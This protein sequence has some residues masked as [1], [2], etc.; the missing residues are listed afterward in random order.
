MTAPSAPR[1]TAVIAS[2]SS[3]ALASLVRYPA[4]PSASAAYTSPRLRLARRSAPRACA[5][6]RAPPRS[7]PARPDRPVSVLSITAT[8]GCCAPIAVERLPAVARLPDELELRALA[9]R[10]RSARPGR[11]AGRPRPGRALA[12]LASHEVPHWERFMSCTSQ[13]RR[14]ALRLLSMSGP[15]G[16]VALLPPSAHGRRRVRLEVHQRPPRVRIPTCLRA[17]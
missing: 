17:P 13:R 4:A 1:A 6:R 2:H 15:A 11:G 16:T 3:R 7:G 5:G 8:S 12:V 14:F 10:A 9:D